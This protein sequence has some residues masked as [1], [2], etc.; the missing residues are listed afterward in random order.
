[1]RCRYLNSAAA[2]DLRG[3]S[4]LFLVDINTVVALA[5]SVGV[6]GNKR[7][8]H[9]GF[10]PK[11]LE[12]WDPPESV[13]HDDGKPHM[14]LIVETYS[15]AERYALANFGGGV[16]IDDERSHYRGDNDSNKHIPEG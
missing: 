10:E 11:P 12:Y 4:E 5:E 16:D 14:Q 15:P 7:F 6:H 3:T 8:R 2:D 9:L 13:R 1:M